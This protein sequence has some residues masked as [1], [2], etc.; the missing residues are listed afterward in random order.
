MGLFGAMALTGIAVPRA[1]R[2]QRALTQTD[3][4]EPPGRRG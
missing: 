3:L 2:F 4:L 1:R